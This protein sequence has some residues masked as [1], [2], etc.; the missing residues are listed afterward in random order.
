MTKEQLAALIKSENLWAARSTLILAIGIL[1]EY[2]ILP[3][4]EKKEKH[5]RSTA[6]T[7]VK[8]AF[9]LLVVA[10]IGGEY[11]FSSK[12][13]D[14]A[15]ELQTL[16]DAE[17]QAVTAD[18]GNTHLAAEKAAAAADRAD[19]SAQQA[20]KAA[21]DAGRAAENSKAVAAKAELLAR[22]ARQEADSFERDIVSAKQQ[23]ASAESHLTEAL[24]RAGETTAALDRLKSP[25]L[26]TIT[27]HLISTLS[28]FKETE[29]TFSSVFA[30]EESLLLLKGLNDVLQ[31][32]GWKRVKPPSAYPAI[33]VFGKDEPFAVP[34]ALTNGISIS[35]DSV[36]DVS[37]LRSLPDDKL[38]MT[39]R[40]A[41]ALYFALSSSFSPP[42]EHPRIVNV[43]KGE[44]K[45]VRIDVGKKP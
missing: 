41:G 28:Q 23:A 39:L 26:V 24:Q 30:D 5:P 11:W 7:L 8:A 35:V 21:G 20:N 40:A 33:D 4:L 13:A 34:T 3:L 18:V 27:P 9:A 10:G 32:A 6:R 2:V 16:A 31:R 15:L 44:S 43:V 38:P 45:T 25:R 1:G 19:A 37:V 22:S 29:Y 36:Q 42:E 17:L 12:I 14:H